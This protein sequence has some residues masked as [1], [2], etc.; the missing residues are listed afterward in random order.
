MFEQQRGP[1]NPTSYAAQQPD[2]TR[3]RTR[4][5]VPM[6]KDPSTHQPPARVNQSVEKSVTQLLVVPVKK[7]SRAKDFYEMTFMLK[8]GDRRHGVREVR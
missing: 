6:S 1:Y 2:I 4:I 5:E 7:A 3:G 8:S